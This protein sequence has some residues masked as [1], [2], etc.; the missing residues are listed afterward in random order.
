MKQ[1]YYFEKNKL[2]RLGGWSL[3]CGLSQEPVQYC[4]NGFGK[5]VTHTGYKTEIFIS[6]FGRQVAFGYQAIKKV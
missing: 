5:P 6:F 2:P 4:M 1:G 3:S